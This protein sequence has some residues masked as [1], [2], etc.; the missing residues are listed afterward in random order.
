[1]NA[2][3]SSSFKSWSMNMETVDEIQRGDLVRVI[4]Q[5]EDLECPCIVDRFG[6]VDEIYDEGYI[7]FQQLSSN[8]NSGFLGGSGP[9]P[10]ECIAPDS[11]TECR[12]LKRK[13]DEYVEKRTKWHD[14]RC[15]MRIEEEKRVASKH[16][17][18][19]QQLQDIAK[20]W[21]AI[22]E[23][24]DQALPYPIF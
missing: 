2:A 9:V 20:N 21:S 12:E 6:F 5:P 13:R 22:E 24:I 14:E 18:T 17:L 16:G 10:F 4:R 11:S 23:R 3:S 15:A 8:S 19:V 7:L 1:M